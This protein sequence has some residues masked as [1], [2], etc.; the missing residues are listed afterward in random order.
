MPPRFPAQ[1]GSAGPQT[2]L[3]L[4]IGMGRGDG[5]LSQPSTLP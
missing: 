2:K 5:S 1:V 3:I 4:V